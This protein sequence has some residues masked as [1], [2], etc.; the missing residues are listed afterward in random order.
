MLKSLAVSNPTCW[1]FE[2]AAIRFRGD[3]CDFKLR[4]FNCYLYDVARESDGLEPRKKNKQKSDSRV[5]FSGR[6]QSGQ[7]SD[8][9]ATGGTTSDSKVT[10]K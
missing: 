9:K 3:S 2:I 10:K 7:K 8:S 6:P 1:R 5:T 4:D